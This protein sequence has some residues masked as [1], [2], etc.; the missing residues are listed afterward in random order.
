[1]TISHSDLPTPPVASDVR[2]QVLAQERHVV[3][4]PF[5][6]KRDIDLIQ[7]RDE[8]FTLFLSAGRE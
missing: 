6:H 5:R 2:L 3:A 7:Q 1:M 8:L 4:L